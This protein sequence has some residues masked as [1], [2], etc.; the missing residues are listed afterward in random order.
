MSE[1]TKGSNKSKKWIF[2]LNLPKE[3]T[4]ESQFF[5]CP[6]VKGS[7]TMYELAMLSNEDPFQKEIDLDAT[8]VPPKELNLEALYAQLERGSERGNPHIQGFFEVFGSVWP[9]WKELKE[10]EKWQKLF[11][12]G[13]QCSIRPAMASKEQ[14]KAY[15][16]KVGN[17]G[18]IPGTSCVIWEKKVK[19]RA[20][21]E[22]QQQGTEEADAEP[23]DRARQRK[24]KNDSA[25]METVLFGKEK[26]KR[27][28]EILDKAVQMQK[29]IAFCV[30]EAH[31]LFTSMKEVETDEDAH[32]IKL[33]K[34]VYDHYAMKTRVMEL[35]LEE[36]KRRKREK[37]N[38]DG[39]IHMRKVFTYVYWGD[40]GTGKSYKARGAFAKY[41][42]VYTKDTT[43]RWWSGYTGQ[44]VV[45]LEELKGD[46]IRAKDQNFTPQYLLRLLDGYDLNLD[47]KCQ[48][49]VPAQY[50]IV[51]ITTNYHFDHWF[52][53]WFGISDTVKE[54]IR[55]R[56]TKFVHFTGANQRDANRRNND[57]DE[58][59]PNEDFAVRISG[60][61]L[62]NDS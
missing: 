53:S 27:V 37:D 43:S 10:D 34:A 28:E 7:F 8:F 23:E 19:K 3:P 16:T 12:K 24:K 29:K 11:G 31:L 32:E 22:E 25:K 42:E 52:D 33:R 60:P 57:A 15:C 21:E 45:V 59:V 20:R 41:G 61:V 30:H 54:A 5:Q 48:E 13:S 17:G 38:L 58:P 2:T 35:Q 39:V 4:E 51:V 6:F 55:S 18:R 44:P 40:S 56:I 47:P 46:G 14:N 26:L 1:K 62:V 50:T 9:T 36:K 49:M